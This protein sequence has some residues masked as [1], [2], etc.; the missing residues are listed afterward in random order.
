LAV[1]LDAVPADVLCAMCDFLPPRGEGSFACTS[2]VGHEHASPPG[3]WVREGEDWITAM[4]C[5]PT[6]GEDALLFMLDAWSEDGRF[7]DYPYNEEFAFIEHWSYYQAEEIYDRRVQR[8]FN[9]VVTE[10]THGTAEFQYEDYQNVFAQH[11]FT[12]V[13]PRELLVKW[14]LGSEG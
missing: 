12:E 14:G 8:D 3:R 2:R 4:G 13:V 7:Y 11:F 5:K 1:S 6:R 9:S 10:L